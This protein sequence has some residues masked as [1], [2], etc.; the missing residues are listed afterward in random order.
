MRGN[1]RGRERVNGIV[2]E[3]LR[4]GGEF[5]SEYK[6]TVLIRGDAPQVVPGEATWQQRD[7]T[8]E[9]ILAEGVRLVA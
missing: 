4:L 6:R 9:D 8:D 5:L 1:E 3:E 2:V 7:E